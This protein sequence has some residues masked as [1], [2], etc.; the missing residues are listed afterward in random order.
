MSDLRA[1][2]DA[3]NDAWNRQDL[4]AVA[5]M[6]RDEIVFHNWTAGERVEGAAQVREHIGRIFESWPTLRFTGR[7]LRVARRL[8]RQRV[9]RAR[10]EGR[11]GARMGRRRRL[12]GRRREDRAQGR[13]LVLAR[14]AASLKGMPAL[15][16]FRVILPVADLDAA[17][18]FYAHVLAT[19]GARVSPGRHRAAARPSSALE[20]LAD[21][22]APM[23]PAQAAVRRARSAI[24]LNLQLLRYASGVSSAIE[25]STTSASRERVLVRR[26]VRVRDRDARASPPPSPSGC[27]CA[28]PRPRRT[29]RRRR[30]A[31]ARP[32]GRRPAPASRARPPPTRPSRGRAARA[33]RRRARRRS[34][35]GST[36]TRARAA[37][38]RASRRTASTAPG[39][40][41][42]ASRVALEHPRDDRAR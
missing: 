41:G 21:R 14:A 17:V 33:R 20:A 25:R 27:R 1:L 2:I 30:R 42:G 37:S 18:A 26:E 38:A 9:D 31:A 28:S 16:L 19:P 11:R 3:Y 5:S 15:Q 12:P 40:S 29:R 35:R 34:A 8:R 7:T 32:R 23:R 10:D 22:A 6:H 24:A 4:D 13:L 39:I 36:T